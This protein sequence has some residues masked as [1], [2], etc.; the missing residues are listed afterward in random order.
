MPWNLFETGL[1]TNQATNLV[2]TFLSFDLGMSS[3][4]AW[5]ASFQMALDPAGLGGFG[6][7]ATGFVNPFPAEALPSLGTTTGS[8]SF[9]TFISA[10]GITNNPSAHYV[11]LDFRPQQV[12]STPEPSTIAVLGAG[13]LG[14]IGLARRRAN[15]SSWASAG[16]GRGSVP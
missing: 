4:T 14:L 11:G 12:T 9:A 15:G 1:Q 16:V 10:T 7:L 3:C 5:G 2:G 6:C 8:S 13:M